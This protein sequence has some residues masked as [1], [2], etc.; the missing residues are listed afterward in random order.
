MVPLERRVETSAKIA[1]R[2]SQDPRTTVVLLP[3]MSRPRSKSSLWQRTGLTGFGKY[4]FKWSMQLQDTS[5]ATISFAV[6]TGRQTSSY[7]GD[8][9]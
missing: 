3:R 7:D 4:D 1:M 5:I 6:T 8:I 9:R 2:N